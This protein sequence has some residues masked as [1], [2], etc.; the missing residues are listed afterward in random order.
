MPPRCQRPT[1]ATT[2]ALARFIHFLTTPPECYLLSNWRAGISKARRHEDG[3]HNNAKT[4]ELLDIFNKIGVVG[5]M[6]NLCAL[7]INDLGAWDG[8]RVTH[9]VHAHDEYLGSIRT[10][11]VPRMASIQCD[12]NISCPECMV[13]VN[14]PF[15]AD[16]GCDQP[17]SMVH[18]INLRNL[19]KTRQPGFY[20]IQSFFEVVNASRSLQALVMKFPVFRLAAGALSERFVLV[21][22]DQP[23]CYVEDGLTYRW[24]DLLGGRIIPKGSFTK[25]GGFFSRT[26]RLQVSGP[27]NEPAQ[28]QHRGLTRSP[29]PKV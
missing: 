2:A 6:H 4:A 28:F 15:I 18:V 19:I 5:R 8:R 10:L 21:G 12:T 24:D 20:K 1:F 11:I 14:G 17:Q 25:V 26:W 13:R 7:P 22:T 29:I 16:F 9:H 27:P 23:P 3:G